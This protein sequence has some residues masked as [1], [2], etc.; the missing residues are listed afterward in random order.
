MADE[1]QIQIDSGV[2]WLMNRLQGYATERMEFLKE[3]IAEGVPRAEYEAMVGRY[4]EAK[5]WRTFVIE[6]IFGEF[7]QTEESQ[8]EDEGLEEMPTDD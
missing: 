3:G 1:G 5:R 2:S 8:L 6:D 4:K 7:Q